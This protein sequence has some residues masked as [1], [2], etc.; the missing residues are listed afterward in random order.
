[1][2]LF[3]FSIICFCT[4]LCHAR[5]DINILSPHGVKNIGGTNNANEEYPASN[6]TDNI[7]ILSP[8]GVVNIVGTNNRK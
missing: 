6:N 1:M 8:D 5:P 2:T 3:I 7:N 4:V